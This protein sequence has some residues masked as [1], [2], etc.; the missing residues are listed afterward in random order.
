MVDALGA[1]GVRWIGNLGDDDLDPHLLMWDIQRT[2]PI[3]S[4][5]RART[6]VAFQLDG[7]APKVSRWWLVVSEGA[8]DICDFDPGY[9]INA[10]VATSL[11]TLTEIWRGDVSWSRALLDGSA[12]VAGDTDARKRCRSGSVSPPGGDPRPAWSQS[13]RQALAPSIT[14]LR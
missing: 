10:T 3:D 2:I 11:R 13:F 4:W 6:T 1:W 5:P 8:V 12:A 9:D 14:P 7:V